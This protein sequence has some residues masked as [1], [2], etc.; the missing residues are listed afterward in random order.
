MKRREALAILS[1]GMVSA[2]LPAKVM[3]AAD[4]KVPGDLIFHI[5][6]KTGKYI[7]SPG[8]LILPSVQHP[9]HAA[10]EITACSPARGPKARLGS[11]GP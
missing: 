8:I 2:I 7:G 6:A 1:S 3:H 5:P 11:T 9:R 4:E 10:G